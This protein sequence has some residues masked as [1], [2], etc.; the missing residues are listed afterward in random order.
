LASGYIHPSP[1]SGKRRVRIYLPEE[2]LDPPVVIRSELPDNGGTS[3]TYAAEQ[4]AAEVIRSHESPTPLAKVEHWPEEGTR[5][6]E[7]TF[8]LVVFSRYEEEERAPY[9]GETRARIG[10][11]TWKR[12]DLAAAKVLVGEKV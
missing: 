10:T 12:L 3:V 5:G 4:L 11:A 1:R 8:E 6:G 7:E 9:L 2:E